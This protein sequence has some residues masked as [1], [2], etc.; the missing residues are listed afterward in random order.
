MKK[1]QHYGHLDLYDKK[2]LYELDVDAR[3]SITKIAKKV[4]LSKETVNFRIKRL[5]K[6]EYITH[7][8]SIINSSLLGYSNYKIFFKFDKLTDK[9]ESNIIQHLLEEKSCANLRVTEGQYDICFVTMHKSPEEFKEF[10]GRF[11]NCFGNYVLQKSIHIIIS[12]HK[13]NQKFFLVGESFHKILFHGKCFDYSLD[14]IDLKIIKLISTQARLKIIDMARTIHEDPKVISYHLKNLEKKRIIAGYFTALNIDL[15]RRSFIQIN[16]S[17]KD[18]SRITNMIDFF[19]FTGT[20]V[21]A[22]ELLG[23]Y[24][25]SVELYVE[26]DSQLRGILS[27]FK[28]KFIHDYI[29][30]DVSRI[31]KEFVVNWS[32]FD[33]YSSTKQSL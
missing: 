13:L 10:L 8:Y 14:D 3:A 5:L 11:N 18:S 12:S 15:F 16:I 7:F 33:A 21:F 25:L 17:V 22:S 20:C 23:K 31:H 4:R 29:S 32:P 30:Y 19:D 6:N 1:I 2:I 27:Q 9:L 24:D 26:N 28:E